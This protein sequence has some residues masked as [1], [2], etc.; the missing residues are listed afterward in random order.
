[1]R[2]GDFQCHHSEAPVT[3]KFISWYKCAMLNGLSCKIQ[4]A[5][6]ETFSENR[7]FLLSPEEMHI[8]SHLNTHRNSFVKDLV[9]V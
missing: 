9:C 4:K 5:S 3:L 1:M 6:F 7:Q 2:E 8:S